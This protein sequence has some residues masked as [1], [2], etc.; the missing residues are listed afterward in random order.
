MNY[1]FIAA[2]CDDL[3]LSCGATINKL[4]HE[5]HNVDAII[6]SHEYDGIDL[7]KEANVAMSKIDLYGAAIIDFKCREFSYNRQ[8]ILHTL[9]ES[10]LGYD[11]YVT[12]SPNSIHQDHKVIGEESL[13]AFKK[14]NL[15]T[16]EH[17][18]NLLQSESN[19]YIEVSEENMANK[20]QAMACY[21]SQQ[22]RQYFDRQYTYSR[23]LL[24]GAKIGV[25]YAESFR[26]VN[27]KG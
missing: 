20:L 25:K 11:Y 5:G 22:H 2:H 14:C 27:M 9:V 8:L 18:W 6:Y 15:I 24:S 4:I 10:N 26:I 23:A 12:H 17:E 19:Y 16:Y 3:E 21:K 13:R 1:L 7:S